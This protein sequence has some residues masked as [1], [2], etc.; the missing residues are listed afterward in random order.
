MCVFLGNVCPVLH[1]VLFA[2]DTVFI[3]INHSLKHLGN[4]YKPISM[5]FIYS[6]PGNYVNS[7]E[8]KAILFTCKKE[9][10]SP[11]LITTPLLFLTKFV[12]DY[13]DNLMTCN[14]Y[15]KYIICNFSKLKLALNAILHKSHAS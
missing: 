12:R 6:V 11:L 9:M 1:L 15:I 2:D 10:S 13:V 3:S 4:V 8:S 5:T 14:H 7:N